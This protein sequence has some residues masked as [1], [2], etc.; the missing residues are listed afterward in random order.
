VRASE[1]IKRQYISAS[2]LPG[3]EDALS[4]ITT[5]SELMITIRQQTIFLI[6]CVAFLTTQVKGYP[7]KFDLEF[8]VLS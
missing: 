7:V 1:S 2:D 4:N 8:T 6:D 5:F 3:Y